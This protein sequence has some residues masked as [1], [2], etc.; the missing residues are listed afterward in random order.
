MVIGPVKH[1]TKI[2]FQNTDDFE[3]YINA[4]DIDYD[5]EDVILSGYVYKLNTPQFNVAKQNTYAKGTVYMQKIVEYP[6]QNC[7]IPN[8]GKCFIKCINY[9]S[10][11]IIQKNFRI[12][13][14][15]NKNEQML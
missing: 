5:S 15:A 12:S 13:I 1:K 4:I 6:G 3:N 11:K 8:S 7:Y 2:R 9:F 14:E 10:K